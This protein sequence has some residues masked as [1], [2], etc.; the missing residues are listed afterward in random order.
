MSRTPPAICNARKPRNFRTRARYSIALVL[1]V[2]ALVAAVGVSAA[3][4]VLGQ[5][6]KRVSV[7][8]WHQTGIAALRV[9]EPA[10]E[11][12]RLPARLWAFFRSRRS[13]APSA[14]TAISEPD[15]RVTAAA[16]V[17]GAAV[18]DRVTGG[19]DPGTDGLALSV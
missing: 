12:E 6:W 8:A 3:N 5:P 9:S 1:L 15:V 13:V 2:F 17:Q 14:A 16:P 10:D 19:A 11:Y 18:G 7:R 4:G